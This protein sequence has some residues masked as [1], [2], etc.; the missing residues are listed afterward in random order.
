MLNLVYHFLNDSY[1][2][3]SHD[4]YRVPCCCDEVFKDEIKKYGSQALG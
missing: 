2:V 1:Y 4:W 3:Y